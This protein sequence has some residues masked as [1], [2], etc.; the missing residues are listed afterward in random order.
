MCST[1]GEG[2]DQLLSL[3]NPTCPW[4]SRG[5]WD[6][7]AGR[8]WSKGEGDVLLSTRGREGDWKILPYLRDLKTQDAAPT[9]PS[10]N[11]AKDWG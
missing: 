10:A 5:Q 11:P 3:S 9:V 1:A 7:Q 8:G 6:W 4:V 2:Q